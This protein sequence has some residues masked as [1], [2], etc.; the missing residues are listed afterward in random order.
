VKEVPLPCTSTVLLDQLLAQAGSI[1]SVVSSVQV[2]VVKADDHLFI[3][4]PS[5]LR[6][7]AEKSRTSTTITNDSV[8]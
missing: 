8:V 4:L 7:P 6:A 2:A 1:A 3:G 5:C